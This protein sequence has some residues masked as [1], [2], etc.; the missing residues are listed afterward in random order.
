V[1]CQ[2]EGCDRHIESASRCLDLLPA[3]AVI[4]QI[5]RLVG[6]GTKT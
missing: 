3:S 5:E 6:G 4:D 1:P 2:L